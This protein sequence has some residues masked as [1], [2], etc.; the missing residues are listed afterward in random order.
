MLSFLP[1]GTFG[2]TPAIACKSPSSP[3]ASRLNGSSRHYRAIGIDPALNFPDPGGR[4]MYIV[5]DREPIRE[6]L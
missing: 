4:P 3:S 6:L 2:H 1:R 5:D